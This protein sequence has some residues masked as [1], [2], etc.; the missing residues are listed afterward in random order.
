M[1]K[2]NRR[3]SSK[4]IVWDEKRWGISKTSL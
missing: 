2:I 1:P 4:P 3:P